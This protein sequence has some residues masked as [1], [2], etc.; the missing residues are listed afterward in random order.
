MTAIEIEIA[1]VIAVDTPMHR[2]CPFVAP[3][4]ASPY[5]IR[6]TC[7]LPFFFS[8]TGDCLDWIRDQTGRLSGS[9]DYREQGENF[10]AKCKNEI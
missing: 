8:G 7:L 2:M 6:K 1:T 4:T 10:S 3:E 9:R 5:R